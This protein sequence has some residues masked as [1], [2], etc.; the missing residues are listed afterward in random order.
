MLAFAQDFGF[1][2]DQGRPLSQPFDVFHGAG[3][4]A[5]TER[6]ELRG[7]AG[8]GR[9]RRKAAGTRLIGAGHG[10]LHAGFHRHAAFRF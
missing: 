2:F 4:G 5:L 6:I 3:R 9:Q 10:W 7:E 8:K 1:V